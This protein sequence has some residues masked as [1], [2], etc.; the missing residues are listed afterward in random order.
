MLFWS[1][2][3]FCKTPISIHY[4]LSITIIIRFIIFLKTG[5]KY[6]VWY[7]FRWK[8]QTWIS[9]SSF[10]V[11]MNFI[12]IFIL[13]FFELIF[14]Y[15]VSLITVFNTLILEIFFFKIFFM[16]CFILLLIFIHC[17]PTLLF[18][19][20]CIS[21][22]RTFYLFK[23]FAKILRINNILALVRLRRNS[24]THISWVHWEN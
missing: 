17:Y 15:H 1:C 18:I 23:Y 10:L 21:F 20:V 12:K 14:F 4:H 24:W 9:L 8:I 2:T 5:S 19:I 6:S 11:I 7:S 3:L 16:N 13:C 22:W